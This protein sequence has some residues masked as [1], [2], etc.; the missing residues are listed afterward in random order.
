MDNSFRN[1]ADEK[2]AKSLSSLKEEFNLIR[3]GK[4]N[5]A[6]FDRIQAEHYGAMTPLNQLA[7]ISV[8]EARL[9]VIQPWDKNALPAIEKAILSSDLSLNPNNDGKVIR[10]N[11]PP[12]TE[13]RRKDLVKQIKAITE[14]HRV[15][16]RGVRRDILEAMK[17]AEI[18][19]DEEKRLKDEIQKLTDK[20][21]KMMDD[22]L[23]EKE[24]EIMEI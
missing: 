2:M 14:K 9:I 3:G 15:S 22:A 16:V 4:A 5:A 24:K 18:P 8:P 23:T 1:D 11:V 21:I 6:I 20:Y 19:E 7:S 10:I 13:E 17:K 12:L